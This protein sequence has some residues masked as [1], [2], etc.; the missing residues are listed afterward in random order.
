M[1]EQLR[2]TATRKRRKW[3]QAQSRLCPRLDWTSAFRES[4]RATVSGPTPG[5]ASNHLCPTNSFRTSQVCVAVATHM[6]ISSVLCVKA[7]TIRS[8]S[9]AERALIKDTAR[10]VF[11]AE[12]SRARRTRGAREGWLRRNNSF[13][14]RERSGK[15]LARR[16][17]TSY[18]QEWNG[19]FALPYRTNVLLI[20]ARVA[21]R[22]VYGLGFGRP[23]LTQPDGQ[24]HH[25]SD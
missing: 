8:L 21:V 20:V 22:A 25:H 18:A 5:R 24:R 19:S 16:S 3:S 9:N 1:P 23:F 15:S 11:I 12:I 17:I 13:L 6:P 7:I 4:A 10:T 2:L 14:K